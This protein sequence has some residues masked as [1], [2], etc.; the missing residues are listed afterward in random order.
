MT[1]NFVLI[2]V[3]PVTSIVNGSAVTIVSLDQLHKNLRRHKREIKKENIKFS[4][5]HETDTKLPV[6]MTLE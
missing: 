1:E 3:L 6:S 2:E 4:T 5:R